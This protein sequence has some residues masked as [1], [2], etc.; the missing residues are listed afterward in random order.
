MALFKSVI[1][2]ARP[3]KSAGQPAYAPA[4][5]SG[6]PLH[7]QNRNNKLNDSGPNASAESIRNP[8][9]SDGLS[10]YGQSAPARPGLPH[11]SGELRESPGHGETDLSADQRNES[12]ITP[13]QNNS[14]AGLIQH[15]G[16]QPAHRTPEIDR[17]IT[18]PAQKTKQPGPDLPVFTLTGR[19]TENTVPAET[20]H[21]NDQLPAPQGIEQFSDYEK[22][23]A[24]H[25]GS[26]AIS[27]DTAAMT[28]GWDDNLD[29]TVQKATRSVES[30]NRADLFSQRE[31]EF[32]A[33]QK[34]KPVE[35]TNRR[36][37]SDSDDGHNSSQA[38]PVEQRT[39]THHSAM[40]LSDETLEPL[41]SELRHQ[42]GRHGDTF[43]QSSSPDNR[44]GKATQQQLT[45]SLPSDHQPTTDRSSASLEPAKDA[46]LRK[47]SSVIQ[48]Q[49]QQQLSA[50]EKQ[51][52]L[53]EARSTSLI[54]DQFAKHDASEHRSLRT[55]GL[56]VPRT[57]E[58]RIGQV[59]VFVEK[60]SPASSRGN[61]ATRPSVSLASRH[62]LRRL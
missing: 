56:E 31:K 50:I 49:H 38:I 40:K 21:G 12:A 33:G 27:D 9:R 59:D 48:Q 35:S 2:D 55:P 51:A 3:A 30:G 28:F 25:T 42:Q 5:L 22:S 26:K 45:G 36:Q 34:L 18:E 24:H 14:A 29:T 44:W 1:S 19:D 57:A 17:P 16:E 39:A 7:A 8:G 41:A 23:T 52:R 53:V 61:T 4:S 11:Y 47:Q 13:L 20:Q 43:R 54:E 10:P 60:S 46:Q 58:V 62:Y 37:F 6:Q 32:H 15:F